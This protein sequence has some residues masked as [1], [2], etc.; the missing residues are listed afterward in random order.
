MRKINLSKFAGAVVVVA[1][2]LAGTVNAQTWNCGAN[3]NVGGAASV[4]AALSGGTLTISGEGAMANYSFN[5][6]RLV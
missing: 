3:T 6:S 1:G 4:T 5:G 2:L